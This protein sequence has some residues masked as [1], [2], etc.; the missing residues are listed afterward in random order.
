[1]TAATVTL[2]LAAWLTAL[3]LGT[4]LLR[5]HPLAVVVGGQLIALGGIMAILSLLGPDGA[6]FAVVVAVSSSLLGSLVLVMLQ[7][8]VSDEAD[9]DGDPLR[10]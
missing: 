4:A 5:R 1:M 8:G 2:M 7:Q 10:W 3:G 6:M 9:E